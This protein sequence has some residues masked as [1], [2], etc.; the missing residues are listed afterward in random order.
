M[1]VKHFFNNK[2]FENYRVKIFSAA[3]AVIV[4]FFVVT[5]NSY[6]HVL[7]VPLHLI[8]KPDDY[9]LKT[10]VPSSVKVKFEGKGKDLILLEYRDKGI[11]LDLHNIRRETVFPLTAE[12]VQNIPSDLNVKPVGIVEPESIRVELDRFAVKRVPV[13]SD[14]TLNLLDGYI[15][16]GKIQFRPDSIEVSGP[17]SLVNPISEVFT[18][19][20]EY[21]GLVKDLKGRMDLRLPDESMLNFSHE[22]V[23]FLVDIQR[24]GEIRFTE[25]PIHV[26][27]V[28]ANLRVVAVPSTLSLTVEGGVE[29]L[30]RLKKED[31]VATIDYSSRYRYPGKKIPAKIELPDE[32]GF[33][34]VRPQFFE[35]LLER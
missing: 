34:E 1:K 10:P 28:P 21:S 7:S 31:I 24:R 23:R 13:R 6:F 33:S 17:R 18:D 22:R 15:Q 27:G 32:V 9:I 14:L 20:R 25:I 8:N 29:I 16:V 4:W 30:S 35:L 11:E 5:D 19:S 3:L 2:W 26:T 12:M